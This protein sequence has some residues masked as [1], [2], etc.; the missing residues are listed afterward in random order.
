MGGILTTEA[1]P[2]PLSCEEATAGEV[3]WDVQSQEGPAL[4]PL[5]QSPATAPFCQI[6]RS[7]ARAEPFPAWASV[8]RCRMRRLS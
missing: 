3:K 4:L 5:T 1:A 2:A 6:R 8:S 7:A